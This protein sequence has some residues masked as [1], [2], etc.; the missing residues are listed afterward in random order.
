MP[1][2]EDWDRALF[3]VGECSGP[4]EEQWREIIKESGVELDAETFSKVIEIPD[5]V[6][7]ELHDAIEGYHAQPTLAEMA[8]ELVAARESRQF[9]DTDPNMLAL[10]NE[11]NFSDRERRTSKQTR[12]LA[13]KAVRDLRQQG[14]GKKRYY[15]QPEGIDP[16]TKCA[17]IVSVKLNWPGVRTR[18][19]QA[20]CQALYAAAGGKTKRGTPN[21]TDG[22]WR[23]RLREAQKLGR[24]HRY[25]RI[26][27]RALIL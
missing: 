27:E 16:A 26:I 11:R 4:S 24:D 1:D 25:S 21:R 8:K 9:D 13:D 23:D 15:P 5:V 17:L 2:K 3:I 22:F 7:K 19:A 6:I 20:A 14:K 10:F 18:Q 12:R